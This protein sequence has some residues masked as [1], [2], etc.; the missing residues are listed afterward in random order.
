[1]VAK[2][3]LHAQKHYSQISKIAISA[4]P[5]TGHE[6]PLSSPGDRQSVLYFVQAHTRSQFSIVL[7]ELHHRGYNG[8]QNVEG[9]G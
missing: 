3:F 9:H 5:K 6:T 2:E 4:T 1:M 7:K 8:E